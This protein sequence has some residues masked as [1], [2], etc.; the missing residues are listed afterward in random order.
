MVDQKVDERLRRIEYLL[1]NRSS[2]P[3]SPQI[4]RLPILPTTPPTGPPAPV[5]TVAKELHTKQ[6]PFSIKLPILTGVMM[7]EPCPLT[8]EITEVTMHFPDGSN[9]YVELQ[10]GHSDVPMFPANKGEYIA[11]N[12]A[13]PSW[14]NL[15]ESVKKG[16]R[17]WA[18]LKNGDAG[19]PHKPSILVTIVGIE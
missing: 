6:V 10:F 4:P 8:G 3:G 7:E 11:L 19:F 5:P 12:N 9:G 15:R 18:E 13:T 2:N 17:L 14:R 1:Q 16:E